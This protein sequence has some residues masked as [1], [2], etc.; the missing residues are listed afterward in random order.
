MNYDWDTCL[1]NDTSIAQ[2][3]H[4]KYNNI[5][6][7]N[8]NNEWEYKNSENGVLEKKDELFIK[9]LLRIISCNDITNR[10]EYW[11]L[12]NIDNFEKKHRL[13][14][15]NNIYKYIMNDI[16]FNRVIKEL[17]FYYI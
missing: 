16:K 1:M 8:D 6:I 13:T 17:K 15:L 10:M 14:I 12:Q 9:N 4:N 2:T 5:I 11:Q 3:L 7:F